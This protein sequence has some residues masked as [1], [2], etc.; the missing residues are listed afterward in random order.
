[1][2]AESDDRHKSESLARPPAATAAERALAEAAARRAAQKPS[3]RPREIDGREGPEP[4]R[5]GDWE[6]RGLASDF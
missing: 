4:T 1:L 2:A 5:Y 3:E 6:V